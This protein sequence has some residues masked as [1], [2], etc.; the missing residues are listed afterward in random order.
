MKKISLTILKALG[1]ILILLYISVCVLFY[2]YQ[3]DFFIFPAQ[4]LDSTFAYDFGGIFE[5]INLTMEDGTVLN[6]L[7]FKAD[8]SKGVILYLHGNGGSLENWGGFASLYTDLNYDVFMVD[9]RGYGKSGGAYNNENEIHEDIQAVYNEVKRRYP[10]NQITVLGYSL[11]SGLATRLASNN[12]PNL[13]ILLAP[14]YNLN[15]AGRH[16][17][18]TVDLLLF[19]LLRP[20]PTSWLNKY[21]FKSNEYIQNC[22]MPIV[23]F[24]GDEDEIVYY[25]SS[26]KLREH[27]KPEDRLITIEGAGH[28][29][30]SE[31]D[32]FIREMG[33]LLGN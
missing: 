14:F 15:D 27:F 23:I 9:Y 16:V 22:N 24:H 25:G 7:L 19:K 32:K 18:N 30:I 3:E 13:L 10:E 11:G 2:V 28:N 17:I 5:E 33:I 1:S 12:D 4:K 20:L 8:S 21:K 6:N 31:N 26:L 29:N